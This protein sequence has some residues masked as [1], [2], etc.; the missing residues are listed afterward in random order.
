MEQMSA[1]DVF[2]QRRDLGRKRAGRLSTRLS[3]VVQTYNFRGRP[4]PDRRLPFSGEVFGLELGVHQQFS[5]KAI[6]KCVILMLKH[7][8]PYHHR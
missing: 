4:A 7:P 2:A 3:A 5:A 6:D 1:N 8:A